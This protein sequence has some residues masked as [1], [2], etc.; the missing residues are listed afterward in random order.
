MEILNGNLIKIIDKFDTRKILVLGDV[1]LDHYVY[2]KVYRISPE[3]PVPIVEVNSESYVPGGAGNVAANISSLGGRVYVLGIIGEDNAGRLLTEELKKRNILTDYLIHD[4]QRPTI[5][6]TRVIAH[7][8]QMVR[9]DQE[10]KDGINAELNNSLL[11]NIE[12][13]IKNIDLIV[14]S[15]YGKG[16]VSQYL[17]D[18]LTKLSAKYNKRILVDPK[19]KN[20]NLYN[21]ISL[22]TPNKNE[23]SEMTGIIEE[24]EDDL[25]NI[26]RT[27]TEKY[28]SD[29]LIT[30][31]EEGMSIFGKNGEIAHMPTKA[32]E[33][34][35]VTGAGDTV[36]AALALSY[37]S[38]ANLREAAYIANHTAGI[39][40]GK[41]G[42]ST[43]SAIEL[44]KSMEN[45]K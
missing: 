13:I 24:T 9:F 8:Q 37:A 25:I 18:N 7:N 28:C 34:Y 19:P 35:D 12:E 4:G 29:V 15:D 23:A 22:I 21:G 5:H 30:R 16:I 17:M 1:M 3:A 6:K 2:G 10:K 41:V 11:N 39:V 33:V 32:K 27:L 38:G 43:V 14:V 44:K 26:G 20:K 36:I 40:V 31:G 45:D 42:T